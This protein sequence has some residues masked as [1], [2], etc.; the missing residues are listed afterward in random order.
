[1][2]EPSSGELNELINLIMYI[3]ISLHHM[4]IKYVCHVRLCVDS[5][6]LIDVFY[7]K[8]LYIIIIVLVY[9]VQVY[10]DMGVQI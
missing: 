8:S 1:M 6:C 4:D 5:I 2:Y 7:N 10:H 3:F 9:H